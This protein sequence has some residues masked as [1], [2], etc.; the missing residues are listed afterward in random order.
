MTIQ[1]V[2]NG[3]NLQL[4]VEGKID[5][6]TCQNFQD[7][8]LKTFQKTNNLVINME[9]VD[10]VSSAGLRALILGQKTASSKGGSMVIIN[11]SSSV[12][13]VFRVTGFDKVLDIR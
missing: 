10:Y 9:K 6:L 3:G 5:S 13:D 8:I 7:T 2:D 1:E 12:K 4:D 11:A